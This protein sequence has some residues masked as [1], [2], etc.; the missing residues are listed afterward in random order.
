MYDARE[1]ET[2]RQGHSR[3]CAHVHRRFAGELQVYFSHAVTLLAPFD[4]CNGL[5]CLAGDVDFPTC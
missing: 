4:Y 2:M 5:S 3:P 1:F